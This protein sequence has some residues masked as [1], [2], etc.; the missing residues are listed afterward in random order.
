M[1]PSQTANVIKI[2]PAE[3]EL[4]QPQFQPAVQ[5]APANVYIQQVDAQSYSADRMSWNFRSP[6]SNLLCSPLVEGVFRVK[7]T[8]PYRLDK[9]QQIGPLLGAYTNNAASG[10]AAICPAMGAAGGAF[11]LVNGYG[12]RQL[13]SFG[14]GNCVSNATESCS[15]T[16]NGATWS[17]LNQNLY[18]R[19]LDKCLVPDSVQQRAWSTCGGAPNRHDSTPV[20]GHALGVSSAIE[21]HARDGADKRQVEMNDAVA[22]DGLAQGYAPTEGSTMD[23]GLT[24]RMHNFYDQ[25]ISV[26]PSSTAVEGFVYTLEIKF[27]LDGCVFNSLWG[28]SGL[29]RSDPRLRMALG[30]PHINQGQ[31]TLQFRALLKSIIRRLGRSNAL[32]AANRHATCVSKIGDDMDIVFDVS[33]PPKLRFTFIRL[34]SFQAYP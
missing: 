31:I 28:Q 20:S 34:P 1:D 27:G 16:L 5:S 17:T 22:G 3:M 11:D 26:V 2:R 10:A 30:L 4:A 14:S 7:I 33:Y 21:Y 15:I 32:G 9:C 8:T 13:M 24:Q 19:S 23:S 18:Q 29:A 25:I 12:Y 6:S